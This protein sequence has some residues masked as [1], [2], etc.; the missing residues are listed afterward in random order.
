MKTLIEHSLL[1]LF[2]TSRKPFQWMF[3][4]LQAELLN[5]VSV[6]GVSDVQF[7]EAF[8]DVLS[9]N[10]LEILIG[11]DK[12]SPGYRSCSLKTGLYLMNS[13]S[14]DN[15]YIQL[16][17]L[18][19]QLWER[20]SE[21]NWEK[22]F[23]LSHDYKKG[24]VASKDLSV[25]VSLLSAH[26]A[27]VSETVSPRLSEVKVEVVGSYE[28]TYWKKLSGVY[29]AEFVLDSKPHPSIL[30]RPLYEGW[31]ESLRWYKGPRETDAWARLRAG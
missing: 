28:M 31:K 12:L 2:C 21:P 19:A 15:L 5:I 22:S 11:D 25:L 7:Q 18:G 20:Y 1:Q 17:T 3:P 27:I 6:P 9:Q 13:D 24:T 26:F 8:I 16:T 29:V 10:K 30:P 14:G 23:M 4:S